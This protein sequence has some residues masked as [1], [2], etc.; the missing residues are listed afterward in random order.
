MLLVEHNMDLVLGNADTV[1][2][3]ATGEVIAAGPPEQVSR[4]PEV[5]AVYLGESVPDDDQVV[6]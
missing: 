2:V 1:H 3:L 6:A 5:L 4:D